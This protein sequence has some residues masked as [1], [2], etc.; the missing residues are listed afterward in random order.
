MH[1]IKLLVK[2]FLISQSHFS[3]ITSVKKPNA[4]KSL[5]QEVQI[6]QQKRRIRLFYNVQ[7]ED[8][9]WP[10]SAKSSQVFIFLFTL[11]SRHYFPKKNM[12]VSTLECYINDDIT[13]VYHNSFLIQLA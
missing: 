7:S 1:N 6:I 3:K 5:K 2:Y 4:L 8:L 10:F 11:L 9:E 13:K 12:N